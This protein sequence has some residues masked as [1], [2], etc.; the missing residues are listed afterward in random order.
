M[1]ERR[2]TCVPPKSA[3]ITAA[4]VVLLLAAAASA[5]PDATIVIESRT[6][7]A[8]DMTFTVRLDANTDVA[9][10]MNDVTFPSDAPIA[11]RSNGRPQCRV[12]PDIGKP[13]TAFAFQ[14]PGCAPSNSCT[15][16]RSIVLSVENVDPIQSAS[17]LY[18]CVLAPETP[19]GRYTL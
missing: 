15:A 11:A 10:T 6:L 9:G 13:G 18:S 3:A 16:V 7:H 19:P 4:A 2:S 17:P 8:G 1:T 5:V 14:P 12:N